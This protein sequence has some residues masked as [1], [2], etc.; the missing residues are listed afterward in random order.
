M[1]NTQLFL[2]F[3]GLILILFSFLRLYYKFRM[4]L[5]HIITLIFLVSSF[6]INIL[7]GNINNQFFASSSYSQFVNGFILFLI[8]IVYSYFYLSHDDFSEIIDISFV[9]SA[10]GSTLIVLSNNLFSLIISLE[11]VAVSSF[12]TVFFRKTDLRLEGLT[13]YIVISSISISIILFGASLIYIGSGSLSFTK[14]NILNSYAL[15]PGLVLVLV[16]LSYEATLVPFHM[17]AVDTYYASDNSITA[18]LIILKSSILVAIIKLFFYAVQYSAGIIRPV[19][20][21]LVIFTI[22]VP[23]LLAISQ[24]RIKRLIVY[25]SIA[26]AGFAFAAISMLNQLAISGAIFYI[27]AFTVSEVLLFLSLNEFESSGANLVDNLYKIKRSSNIY[28]VSFVVGL[29]SLAGVPPFIGFFGKFIIIYSLLYSGY[30]WLVIILIFLLLFSTFYYV[31]PIVKMMSTPEFLIFKKH[32]SNKEK[33]KILIILLL[34]FIVIF[35]SM[36]INI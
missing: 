31:K 1:I 32:Y 27:F 30:L 35:G 17:W 16:G 26:Q 2:L 20:L 23:S 19:L 9:F 34:V 8:S 6:L 7:Y 33:L 18:L 14:I 10:L 22:L 4:K 24:E 36:Y 28:A 13:K 29:L 5:I 21:F 15:I 11:L 25:S 12:S 3:S